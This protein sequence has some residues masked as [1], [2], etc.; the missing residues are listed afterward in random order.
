VVRLDGLVVVESRP[1]MTPEEWRRDP[2]AVLRYHV[3]LRPLVLGAGVY[4]ATVEVRDGEEVA[5]MRSFVLEVTARQTPTG[6]R[7]ALLYPCAVRAQLVG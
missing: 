5:A 1:R 4:C 6:G 3:A 7:P 2:A